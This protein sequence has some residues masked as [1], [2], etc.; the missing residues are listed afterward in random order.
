MQNVDYLVDKHC[1]R[2][3]QLNHDYTSTGHSDLL[4]RLKRSV[5]GL[6]TTVQEHPYMV[7]IR[8]EGGH[9]CG[10]TILSETVILTAGQC[11]E[12]DT[13][14][15]LLYVKVGDT[16][17]NFKGSW[18]K[19]NETILHN[20]YQKLKL[21]RGDS[22]Y[23]V[24]DL[25]LLKLESPITIDN[26]TTKVVQLFDQDEE[27]HGYDRGTIVGWGYT[28]VIVTD[29][30]ERNS[31]ITTRRRVQRLS[32][33]LAQV[34]LDIV[35]EKKCSE[36]APESDLNGQFCTY[37]L[38]RVACYGDFGGP[39][40]L[41]GRQAGIMSWT[42]ATQSNLCYQG[43]AFTAFTEITKFRKW[44]DEHTKVLSGKN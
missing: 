3:H 10:G 18:H 40:M 19:V 12:P 8:Y 23:F 34:E 11:V 14:L 16:D 22:T 5:G 39:I 36:L 26:I 43:Y 29:P 30:M 37:T 21:A 44:I 41:R 35:S 33:K 4:T 32:T 24:N 1:N 9:I 25:A 2:F 28:P 15:D 7:S 13:F 20:E 38:G 17:I 27:V 31:S 42:Q 6:L